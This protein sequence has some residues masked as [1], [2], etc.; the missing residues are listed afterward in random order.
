MDI[1]LAADVLDD[2]APAGSIV[3]DSMNRRSETPFLEHHGRDDDLANVGF[4][5]LDTGKVL[6]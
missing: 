1:E 3:R 4:H 6:Q 2:D 5:F